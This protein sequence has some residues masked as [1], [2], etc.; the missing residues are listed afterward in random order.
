M[1]CGVVGVGFGLCCFGCVDGCGVR[2]WDLF[3]FIVGCYGDGW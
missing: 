1:F 2:M 3:V